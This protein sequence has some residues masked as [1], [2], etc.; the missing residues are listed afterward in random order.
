MTS[1]AGRPRVPGSVPPQDPAEQRRKKPSS[2]S[3][4]SI[5][6]GCGEDGEGVYIRV[7]GT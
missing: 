1:E 4:L 5:R 7:H 3:C 6:Y 2:F